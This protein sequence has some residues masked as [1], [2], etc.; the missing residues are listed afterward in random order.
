MRESLRDFPAGT[1]AKDPFCN[2]GDTGLIPGWG[3]ELPHAVEQLSWCS[4]TRQ[5]AARR[6]SLCPNESPMQSKK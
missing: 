2:A 3:N 4:E 5:H 1:V 6:A